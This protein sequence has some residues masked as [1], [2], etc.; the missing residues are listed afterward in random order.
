MSV[1]CP[2]CKDENLDNATYCRSCGSSLV[3]SIDMSTQQYS[4]IGGWLILIAIM[5]AISLL[6]T[7]AGILGAGTFLGDKEFIA[8]NP[9]IE[10]L[11]FSQ[12][13]IAFIW[14]GLLTYSVYLFL[15]KK[16]SFPKIYSSFIVL[17]LIINIPSGYAWIS[18]FP[19]DTA[20]TFIGLFIAVLE[21]SITIPYLFLSKRAR[22]TF[23]N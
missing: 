16:R 5:M 2:Q 3:V 13:M 22:G 21:A 17:L 1:I 11:L 15:A 8:N 23:V 18:Y 9:G 14:I 12:L 7:L 19:E 4:A 10:S 6:L 20:S